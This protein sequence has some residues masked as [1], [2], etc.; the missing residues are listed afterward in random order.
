MALLEYGTGNLVTEEEMNRQ[1]QLNP[2]TKWYQ[3]SAGKIKM[4]INGADCPAAL[5]NHECAQYKNCPANVQ[6]QKD[7]A[8]G[9]IWVTS[10][11]N[12]PGPVHGVVTWLALDYNFPAAERL[13]TTAAQA[14]WRSYTCPNCHKGAPPLVEDVGPHGVRMANGHFFQQ[15]A[16]ANAA[17]LHTC[18]PSA[19]NCMRAAGYATNVTTI[20]ADNNSNYNVFLPMSKVPS[21]KCG[22]GF[23]ESNDSTHKA[24]Q[25]PLVIRT[26]MAASVKPLNQYESAY[27]QLHLPNPETSIRA[28]K[29]LV[30]AH[31]INNANPAYRRRIL[32]ILQEGHMDDITLGSIHNLEQL[33]RHDL[34]QRQLRTEQLARTTAQ[35]QQPITPW[36]SSQSR[37]SAEQRKSHTTHHFQSVSFSGTRANRWNSI[38]TVPSPVVSLPAISLSSLPALANPQAPTNPPPILRHIR[39]QVSSP[40]VSTAANNN[41]V[42]TA[43]AS[44]SKLTKSQ[45]RQRKKSKQRDVLCQ[46]WGGSEGTLCC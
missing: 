16:S 40:V 11:K 42:Q 46:Y 24:I 6:L 7:T 20:A 13:A 35:S 31:T 3:V 21:N 29:E 23:K 33:Q 19:L 2:S 15:R 44:T 32:S 43:A 26:Y 41:A 34:S 10:I 9:K 1:H 12:I 30:L 18:R 8:T 25:P 38:G 22:M 37:R 17:W 5:I 36:E 4:Y 45:I 27:A 14:W 39:E 28:N